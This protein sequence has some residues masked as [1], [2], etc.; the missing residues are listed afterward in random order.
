MKQLRKIYDKNCLY[1]DSFFFLKKKSDLFSKFLSIAKSGSQLAIDEST[2]CPPEGFADDHMAFNNWMPDFKLKIIMKVQKK[3]KQ[4]T[5]CFT[6]MVKMYYGN[7]NVH[8]QL[9]TDDYGF[10]CYSEG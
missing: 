7:M 10:K 3:Y 2:Y 8:Q 9:S 5:W 4:S 6:T 1:L